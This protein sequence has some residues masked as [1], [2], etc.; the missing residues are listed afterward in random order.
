MSPEVQFLVSACGPRSAVVG[1]CRLISRPG[2]PSLATYPS[3]CHVTSETGSRAQARVRGLAGL[4]GCVQGSPAPSL[5]AFAGDK[6]QALVSGGLE[7]RP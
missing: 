7:V 5:L 6:G 3:V 2:S 4:P 1:C